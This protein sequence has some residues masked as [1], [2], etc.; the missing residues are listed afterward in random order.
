VAKTKQQKLTEETT[1]EMANEKLVVTGFDLFMYETNA[2]TSAQIAYAIDGEAKPF[3]K[4]WCITRMLD[5]EIHIDR[6]EV[7]NVLREATALGYELADEFGGV[8]DGSELYVHGL[9]ATAENLRAIFGG[10]NSAEQ[11]N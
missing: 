10:S 6:E 2:E 11:I 8:C 1:M 5:E 4:G 3:G 9:H 7:L